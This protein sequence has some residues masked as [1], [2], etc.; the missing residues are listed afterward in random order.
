[1]EFVLQATE[2]TEVRENSLL[3][4]STEFQFGFSLLDFNVMM[5]IDE[6]IEKIYELK[7]IKIVQEHDGQV[8]V[9]QGS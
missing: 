2:F 3:I 6:Q 7:D 5:P 1:M 4:H 9:K 8:F